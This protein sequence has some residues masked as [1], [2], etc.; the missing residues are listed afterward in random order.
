MNVLQVALATNFKAARFASDQHT[1]ILREMQ[2]QIE[3]IRYGP[4][5]VQ[6]TCQ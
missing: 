2:A 5:T 1:A 6:S 3:A 4:V